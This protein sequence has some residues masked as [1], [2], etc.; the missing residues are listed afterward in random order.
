MDKTQADNFSLGFLTAKCFSSIIPA[1]AFFILLGFPHFA[2]ANSQTDVWGVLVVSVPDKV[3]LDKEGETVVSYILRQTHEPL[4]RKADGQNFTSKILRDWSRS[5]NYTEYTLCPDTSLKFSD[6]TAFSMDFFYSYLSSATKRYSPNFSIERNVGCAIVRFQTARKGYLDFLTRYEQAPSINQSG[7]ISFGLGP[8][9]VAVLTDKK[10][11][12]RRKKT[13]TDGY[14]TVA[15]YTY[16]DA[17]DNLKKT[18]IS[19][20]NKLP[21]SQQPEWISRDFQSFRNIELVSVGLAISHPDK[22]VRQ[23]L[24]NCI[25]TKEF[26]EAYAPI[27][28]KQFFDIKTVL[29]VGVSGAQAGKPEQRCRIQAGVKGKEIILANPRINNEET[30]AQYADNF[31]K[32]TG[33]RIKVRKFLPNQINPMLYDKKN[34]RPYN[35][36]VVTVGALGAE[37]S[38][39]LKLY[40]G[41][42]LAV[43]Y[44]PGHIRQMYREIIKEEDIEKKNYLSQ[45]L[46]EELNREYLVLPLYQTAGTLYYP[47]KIKNLSVG[48]GAVEYPEVADLRW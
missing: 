36:L 48:R 23:M 42:P 29:P 26:R 17:D 19:D 21:T 47:R 4:F 3:V 14:N 25:D 1:F 31:F 2:R 38:E 20:F 13:V 34:I 9:Y 35:L 27:T 28:R 40:S 7:N 43:D 37:I 41:S 33:F 39:F 15:F 11:E 8:F 16:S 46:A 6:S 30:L 24:F 32:K 10:V 5:I 22:S 45:N 18:G 12:L 44:V